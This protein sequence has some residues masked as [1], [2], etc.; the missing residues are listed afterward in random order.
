MPATRRIWL[1]ADDYGIAPGVNEAIRRLIAQRRINATSVM[2]VAPAF[3][4]E[5]AAALTALNAS[6]KRAR[7]GL[8]VT[9]TAPFAPVSEGYRP[10]RAHGFPPIGEMM[11]L[12]TARRLS[13][14]RLTGEIGSQLRLFVDAFGRPPDFLDGH[15]HV[16]LLPQ[17]RD[18]L[19]KVAREAAPAAWVRQCGR[20]RGARGLRDR[21]A[22]LLDM[23]SVRFRSKAAR[24][25]VKTNPA[26][27]GSYDFV[28]KAD[29]A[30]IF[31]RFLAGMP[32]GGLIMCHPGLVDDALKRLDPLTDLRERELSYFESDAF[33]RL[34]GERGVALAAA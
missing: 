2:V 17:V 6:H 29:Y 23:M 7:I 12:A 5:A 26:F 21:K 9:L 20:P 4:R 22:L 16:H 30:A 33:T 34:L 28:A 27:A 25:G 15:Q 10:L 32:D 24:L 31:P 19:L 8:H 1:C 14:E 11:R 3:T 18:A 13:A